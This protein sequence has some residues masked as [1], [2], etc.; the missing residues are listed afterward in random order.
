MDNE[1]LKA[2]YEE[3]RRQ[4]RYSKIMTVILAAMLCVLLAAVSVVVPPVLKTLSLAGDTMADVRAIVAQANGSLE[5]LSGT[6]EEISVMTKSITRTSEST[7]SAL[8]QVDFE[9]MNDAI[10][11]LRDAVEPLAN[12]TRRFGGG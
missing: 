8:E 11:N 12:F 3:T 2:L 1:T 4:S 6:M 10:N 5:E 9:A 7:N